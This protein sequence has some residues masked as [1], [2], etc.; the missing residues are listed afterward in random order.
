[1]RHKGIDGATLIKQLCISMS[2]LEEEGRMAVQNH[3]KYPEWSEALDR[4]TKANER[5][6]EALKRK[7]SAIKTYE[8][9]LEKA[10]EQYDRIASEID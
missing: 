4:L 2:L 3:P 6:L 7:D 1:L 9:D 10:K 8:H 5:Y